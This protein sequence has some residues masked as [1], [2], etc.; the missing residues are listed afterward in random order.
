MAADV[1]VLI[2]SKDRACQLDLLLRS[3]EK[4]APDLNRS[5]TVLYRASLMSFDLGYDRLRD[6][7]PRVTFR[8]EGGFEEDVRAW[9]AHP[10]RQTISFLVD[11]DV[12]YAPVPPVEAL[13][14]AFRLSRTVRW[15]ESADPEESYPLCLGGTIYD[16]ATILPLLDFHFS[17]PTQLEAGMACNYSRF[18]P[19]TLYSGGQC[20]VNVPAN[21]VSESSGNPASLSPETQPAELNR[22]FLAG[23][24]LSLSKM[25]FS[26]ITGAHQLV[27]YVWEGGNAMTTPDEAST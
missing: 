5:I 16:K 23:E 10:G 6:W 1:D 21:L 11:D 27:P 15:R 3:V 19:E 13:P 26:N 8:R 25:D 20:H 7:E 2:F 24:R 22:R 18:E 9:L 4:F 14:F 17:N 12:F